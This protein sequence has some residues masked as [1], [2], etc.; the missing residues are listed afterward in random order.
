LGDVDLGAAV[1]MTFRDRAY[2]APQD[3]YYDDEVSIRE[4]HWLVE[5]GDSVIDVGAGYGSYTLPALAYGARV[6]AIDSDQ[7]ALDVLTA[8]AAL[9]GF[10]EL[11]TLRMAVFDGHNGL[12][13]ALKRQHRRSPHSPPRGV[14]WATLDG[15]ATTGVFGKVVDWIK[16]D[17]EGAELG[18]LQGGTGLLKAH[19]PTLIVEDHSRV[20]EW[21]R[22]ER[23]ATRIA[24]L[25]HGLGYRIEW[26]PYIVGGTAPR[27]YLIGTHA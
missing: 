19:H 13:L 9:N 8:T 24:D 11:T 15:L 7:A 4:A 1:E 25:L 10:A 5:P 6:A 18:V 20:Y 21:V 12:P 27:D 3:F 26:V 14:H 16:V 17:V 22:R 2:L 23:I